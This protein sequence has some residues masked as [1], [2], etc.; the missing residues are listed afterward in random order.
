[1]EK[2]EKF[3]YRLSVELTESEW[4]QLKIAL[5]WLKETTEYFQGKGSNQY[6]Q[7][8]RL[9][10]KIYQGCSVINPVDIDTLDDDELPF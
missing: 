3:D 4:F 5:D 9:E 2:K 6:E 1:M 8:K 7:I 10:E